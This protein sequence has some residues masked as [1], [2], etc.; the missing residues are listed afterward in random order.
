MGIKDRHW[1]LA[2]L[3]QAF[4]SPLDPGLVSREVARIGCI[5]EPVAVGLWHCILALADWSDE[6]RRL[7]HAAGRFSAPLGH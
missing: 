3:A 5:D 1:L 4:S 6:I 2:N 7:P